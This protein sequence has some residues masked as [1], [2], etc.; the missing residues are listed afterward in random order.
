MW[1]NFPMIYLDHNATTPLD[2][3][4]LAEMLPYLQGPAA[5]ASSIHSLGRRARSAVEHAREQ[6]ASWLNAHP[7]QVIFT[8]SGTEAN[9]L[10]IKG[11]AARNIPGAMAASLIEHPSVLKPMVG[12]M[13]SGWRI[14]KLAAD[15]QGRCL[16]PELASDVR[17]LAVMLANNE[18]GVLQDISK[19]AECARRVKAVL[20][21]DAVQAA[22]KIP[23][24]FSNSGAQLMS[25]SSHKIYGPQGAGALLRDK[26]IDLGPLI[27]GGGQEADL[28]SG[29]YNVAAI[30]GFGKAA[31]LAAA[32]W[33]TRHEI[34]SRLRDQ[35]EAG[36]ALM[37]EV[38]VFAQAVPRL[39]NTTLFALRGIASE[40]LL[41]N[42]DKLGFAV[43]SG[44]ACSSGKGEPSHVLQAMPIARGLLD[45][46][47]RVSLGHENQAHEISAFLSALQ[48]QVKGLAAYHT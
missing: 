38:T 17:L 39:P 10:A 28:R 5:N 16:F 32:E 15:D 30:V 26:A 27:E 3:R 21:V 6:V 43:S 24:D 37:P 13:R 20:L 36:L 35:L 11:I 12:L 4:V 41:M 34:V 14:E 42:L 8:A 1:Y 33:K 44:S 23:V 19:A 48:R 40:T 2:E 29:T 25:V 18:S 46:V 45:S 9:N 47:V 31:E 7:S 22:G